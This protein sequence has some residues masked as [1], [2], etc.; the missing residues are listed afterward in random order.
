MADWEQLHP[1][2]QFDDDTHAQEMLPT[3]FQELQ[4]LPNQ[5]SID[6][7]MQILKALFVANPKLSTIQRM[8]ISLEYALKM[9]AEGTFC[10]SKLQV[11]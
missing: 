5:N 3:R 6:I 9:G 8:H 10:S 11:K 4:K 1:Q 2:Q 7:P